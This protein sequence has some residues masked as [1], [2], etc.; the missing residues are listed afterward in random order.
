MLAFFALTGAALTPFPKQEKALWGV[1]VVVERGYLGM[2]SG[3]P[4]AT[5]ESTLYDD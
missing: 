4:C 1:L 2:P 5:N 3:S